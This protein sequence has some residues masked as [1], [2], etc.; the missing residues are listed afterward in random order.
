MPKKSK[1]EESGGAVSDRN[2]IL[3]KIGNKIRELRATANLSQ[4]QLAEAA[5]LSPPHMTL[6]EAGGPNISVIT[7]C[8]IAQVLGVSPAVFFDDRDDPTSIGPVFAKLAADLHRADEVLENQRD[9]LSKILRDL[10]YRLDQIDK[11]KKA[12]AKKN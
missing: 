3:V 4:R 2:P 6:L 12:K 10:E 8:T 7:L 11:T 5:G 1:D 9:T